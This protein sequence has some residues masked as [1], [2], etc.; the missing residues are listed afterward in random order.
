MKIKT[1]KKQ[2][3]FGVPIFVWVHV[4]Y[5]VIK[6]IECNKTENDA[7]LLSMKQETRDWMKHLPYNRKNYLIQRHVRG[8][9]TLSLGYNTD[10]RLVLLT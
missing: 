7:I 10:Y 3:Y 9:Q 4:K 2:S 8:H 6:I 5:A 1:C